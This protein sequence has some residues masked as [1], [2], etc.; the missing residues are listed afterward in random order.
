MYWPGSAYF[1]WKCL[2]IKD[3]GRRKRRKHQ[4]K[5]R[6]SPFLK[7]FLILLPSWKK[8]ASRK[9]IFFF[10]LSH[11][12]EGGKR[13]EINRLWEE[14]SLGK[15]KKPKNARW[16]KK[17]SKRPRGLHSHLNDYQYII[18]EKSAIKMH[19]RSES[20]ILIFTAP[21]AN[22]KI[23]CASLLFKWHINGSPKFSAS[24]LHS[25]LQVNGTIFWKWVV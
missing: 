24:E 16:G 19:I 17:R 23:C 6:P 2:P 18:A 25:F 4:L 14:I 1:F 10:G 8:K 11:F 15:E 9:K 5:S 20:R 22:C 21:D 3:Q 12:W 7:T 13:R